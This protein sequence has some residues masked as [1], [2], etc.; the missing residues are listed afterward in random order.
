VVKATGPE[1]AIQRHWFDADYRHEITAEYL[2]L[3]KKAVQLRRSDGKKLSVPLAKLSP[4]DQAFLRLFHPKA[5]E[6]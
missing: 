3:N 6:K 2:G 1:A 5:F 4:Q